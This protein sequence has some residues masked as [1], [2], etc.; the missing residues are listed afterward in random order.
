M[1]GNV[2]VNKDQKAEVVMKNREKE[3]AKH[4][5][6]AIIVLALVVT[7]IV[8]AIKFIKK[9]PESI[10]LLNE[11][12]EPLGTY[13]EGSN[14]QIPTKKG[15][16]TFWIAESGQS[17]SSLSDALASGEASVK[18][19]FSPISYT[20]TLYLTGGQLAEDLGYEHHEA[21]EDKLNLGDYYTR[22]Y[23]IEDEN[24]DLPAIERT[25]STLAS[26]KGNSFYFWSNV[27]Y[28]GTNYKMDDLKA[29]E[30]KT[31]S[32]QEASD[33]VLYAA[34]KPV[35]CTIHVFNVDGTL[36]FFEEHQE[37]SLLSEEALTTTVL[38]HEKTPLG[39]EFVGFCSDS[40]LNNAFDF[41]QEISHQTTA[42]Y[43]KWNAL[44]Y[45]LTF[46]DT[47][48]DTIKTQTFK[49]ND[50]IEFYDYTER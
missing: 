18:Q 27:N 48:G 5:L 24:F 25:T 26:K 47:N 21:S 17:F 38:T 32:T 14:I 16:A 19:S 49:T 28:I 11:A 6:I 40:K 45:T 15:Y 7:S 13:S 30:V 8:L 20:V 50:E 12:G 41:E 44:P 35:M 3:Y 37:S 9:P 31:I 34:W 46:K 42:I 43:T 22:T 39:Y 10:Q 2:E 1:K 33:I 36:M 23:T 29:T 4:T